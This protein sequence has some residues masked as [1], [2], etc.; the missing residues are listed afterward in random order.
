M[1]KLFELFMSEPDMAVPMVKACIEKYKPAIYALLQDL[2]EIYKDYAN[3]TE[4]TAIAAKAKKNMYD[5]LVGVGFSEEQAMALMINDNI[6]LMNNFKA[7]TAKA[8][9]KNIAR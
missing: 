4:Y 5:A 2:L 8:T 6:K 7:N 1:E 3:N 9:A